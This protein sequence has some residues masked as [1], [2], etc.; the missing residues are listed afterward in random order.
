LHIK[1]VRVLM[2]G[3]FYPLGSS[4][5]FPVDE[6]VL[7]HERSAD[8][9]DGKVVAFQPEEGIPD[10]ERIPYGDE[11]P[12]GH[13]DPERNLPP[14]HCQSYG[15]RSD[16]YILSFSQLH[17]TPITTDGI[18]SHSEKGEK[19]ELDGDSLDKGSRSKPGKD[20]KEKG[21]DGKANLF[22]F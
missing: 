20:Q 12:D 14:D 10:Y 18:P 2:N 6:D 11:D 19:E 8:S 3:K 5:Q 15:I 4:D 9:G 21:E 1:K 17:L 7:E 16:P 22:W 13:G